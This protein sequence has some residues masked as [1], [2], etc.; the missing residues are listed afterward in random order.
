MPSGGCKGAR[1]GICFSEKWVRTWVEVRENVGAVKR[2][3][4]SVSVIF[5]DEHKAGVREPRVSDLVEGE[6]GSVVAHLWLDEDRRRR[7]GCH[8]MRAGV[9]LMGLNGS[10]IGT[11]AAIPDLDPQDTQAE[12]GVRAAGT[13]ASVAC[14]D[15]QGVPITG[16]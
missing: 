11:C 14:D 1:H 3:C 15:P 2:T 4:F 16:H 10:S 9:A 5:S 8:A 7:M 6:R 13:I 12:L